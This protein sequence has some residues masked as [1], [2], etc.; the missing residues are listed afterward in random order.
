MQGHRV[1]VA[2]L[3]CLGIV[4]P[5]G[6]GGDA[7]AARTAPSASRSF[8]VRALAGSTFVDPQGT[9]T[10]TVAPTW[11][12]RPGTVVAEVE[13]WQVAPRA[14]GFTP[15]VNVLTQDTAGA[16]F[17]RYR[18]IS[19]RSLAGTPGARVYAS[20]TRTERDGT[21]LGWI[22]YAAPFG[23]HRLHAFGVFGIW[24]GHAI[25]A[26]LTA[27]PGNFGKL[28]SK[29]APYLFTLGPP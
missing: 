11:K 21:R 20:G 2:A 29:F 6:Y 4:V 1:A 22:D 3:L 15:N 5:V 16:S 10:I 25:V 28:R 23:R 27:L 19:L 9:Y 24:Q 12:R 26:T 17:R 13:A 7:N 14:N 18:A 8:P